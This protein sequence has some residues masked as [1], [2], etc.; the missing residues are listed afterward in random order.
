MLENI[1]LLFCTFSHGVDG[2]EYARI[3]HK[4]S[5]DELGKFSHPL[6]RKGVTLLII[7]HDLDTLK[8]CKRVLTINDGKMTS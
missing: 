3:L 2:E 8:Y 1:T 4:L 5:E 6:T 7:S